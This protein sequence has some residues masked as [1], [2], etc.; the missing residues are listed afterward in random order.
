MKAPSLNRAYLASVLPTF[1]KISLR[2]APDTPGTLYAIPSH[3][4][5][6]ADDRFK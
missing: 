4:F 5:R 2:G 3:A 6:G 1:A